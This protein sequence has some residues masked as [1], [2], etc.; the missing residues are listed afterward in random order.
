MSDEETERVST[1]LTDD[2]M[3]LICAGLEGLADRTIADP[4]ERLLKKLG[5]EVQPWIT[6]K[7]TKERLTHEINLKLQAGEI[8]Q[9]EALSIQRDAYSKVAAQTQVAD[10]GA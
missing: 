8:T 6:E 5:F 1:D 2:E 7:A 4:V 10:G 9:E 3:I